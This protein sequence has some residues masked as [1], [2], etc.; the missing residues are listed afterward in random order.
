MHFI[1]KKQIQVCKLYG[2]VLNF[3]LSL[4]P[5]CILET[6]F[7][8]LKLMRCPPHHDDYRGHTVDVTVGMWGK[9]K[10]SQNYIFR[11]RDEKKPPC[12]LWQFCSVLKTGHLPPSLMRQ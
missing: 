3:L 8:S 12:K 11:L 6:L 2:L 9:S 10:L 1:A 7:V 4:Q 5:S